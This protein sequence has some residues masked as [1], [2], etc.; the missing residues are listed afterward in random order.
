MLL[1]STHAACMC[2]HT[3]RGA[4]WIYL[5]VDTRMPLEAPAKGTA[6]PPM[7]MRV[8]RKAFAPGGKAAA[9]GTLAS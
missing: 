5:Y 1:K 8:H 2:A 6:T 9:A 4:S 3:V 7:H